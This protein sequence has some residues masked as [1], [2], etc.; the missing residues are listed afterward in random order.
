M[1]KKKSINKRELDNRTRTTTYGLCCIALLNFD[2]Y[3][4]LTQHVWKL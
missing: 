2:R 3:E 4:I 1:T